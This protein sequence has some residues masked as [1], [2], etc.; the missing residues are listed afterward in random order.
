MAYLNI[1]DAIPHR[2]EGEAVL[3]DHIPISAKRVLDLGT[4]NGRLLKMI[5]IIRPNVEGVGVD[6]S[7][8]MLKAHKRI[9]LETSRLK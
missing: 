5:K 2:S 9:L 7:P 3:L 8:A 6:I 1:I 4:G